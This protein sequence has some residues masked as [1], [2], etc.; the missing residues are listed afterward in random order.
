MADDTKQL[1]MYKQG[2]KKDSHLVVC[3]TI[4]DQYQEIYNLFN[5]NCLVVTTN[6]KIV[7]HYGL[8]VEGNYGWYYIDPLKD[9]F[10]NQLGLKTTFFGISPTKYSNITEEYPFLINLSPEYVKNLD[11]ELKLLVNGIYMDTFF[12][13]LHTEMTNNKEYVFFSTNRNDQYSLMMKKLKY[14]KKYLINLG[15]IPGIYERNIFYNMLISCCFN[16]REKK[17][18]SSKIINDNSNYLI[19][20]NLTSKHQTDKELIYHEIKDNEKYYLKKL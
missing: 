17:F 16:K 9:L 4:C 20:I 19:E 2:F 12:E 6:K 11:K 1:K 18:I 7:P 10:A 8:I 5:I 3:K 13:M 14:I 15:N